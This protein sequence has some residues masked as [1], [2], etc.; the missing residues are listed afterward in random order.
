MSTTR[1]PL[2]LPGRFLNCNNRP[3][4]RLL[5]IQQMTLYGFRKGYQPE[6]VSQ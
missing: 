5:L 2:G 4:I 1:L 3:L 6:A